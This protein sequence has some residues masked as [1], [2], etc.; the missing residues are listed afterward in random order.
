VPSPAL[1]LSALDLHEILLAR[2]PGA[3][4]FIL[5][6]DYN[7][8]TD[9]A[10][11][12]FKQE[13]ADDLLAKFGGQWQEFFDCENFALEALTLAARKHWQARRD[14]R[15]NAQGVAI[16]LLCFLQRPF[17]GASGHCLNFRVHPDRTVTEFE[18]QDRRDLTL[19]PEQCESAFLALLC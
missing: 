14:G 5:D 13:L 19:T 6:R 17:D 2:Y 7:V 10:F 15:G 1:Q 11:A 18:P 8:P 12:L 3:A 16:G 9:A 4:R